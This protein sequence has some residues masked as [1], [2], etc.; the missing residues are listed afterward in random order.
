MKQLLKQRELL[1]LVIIALMVGLFASRAP[2]FAS[3]GNLA[4]IF[5]DTSIL[6]IIALGQMAVILT[7]SIDLS[8]AANLA[9]TGMAVAMLNATYPGL[10]LVLLIVLAVGIGAV[11]GAINGILVWKLNIPAIVV[12]LGTLTIYRGMAFVLSGG[13]WVNAHQMTAP[14][15]NTPRTVVFG[16]PLLGWTAILIVALIYVL[17]TRT[18]FGRALYASGGNPTAAVYTGIDV[19][20]TRFFAFVLSGALAGLCGYLWVSRYA[21]AYVD[22]A[23]GFELDSVAACVIGGISTL[24]GIGTV[25]G[26]VLGALFLGVIKNALPVIDISPFWQ[27]AISGSVIILAVIFNAR[28]EKRRGRIILRDKAAK[29]YEE[30]AA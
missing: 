19:G 18:F 29:T 20:R 14:F 27:M 3:A 12:T 22:V 17:L 6:I 21:V 15:L 4:N 13:A 8:V 2:G 7:K 24:G 10:P 25:A 30:A 28:Q 9:F 11:L 23:A 5:N 26:A 16:L 1:L